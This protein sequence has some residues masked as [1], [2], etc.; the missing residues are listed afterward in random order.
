MFLATATSVVDFSEANAM[1]IATGA[2]AIGLGLAAL[3]TKLGLKY[4]K[5]LFR[6]IIG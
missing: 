3:G 1:V 4:G 2:A 5:S 6:S